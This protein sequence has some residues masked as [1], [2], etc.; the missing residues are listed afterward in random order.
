M[1]RVH[2]VVAVVRCVEGLCGRWCGD[3]ERCFAAGSGMRADIVGHGVADAGSL[4]DV[5]HC[6]AGSEGGQ[7]K[8]VCFVFGVSSLDRCMGCWMRL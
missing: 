2:G 5:A 6:N 1:C 3:L 4:F 8:A 7:V